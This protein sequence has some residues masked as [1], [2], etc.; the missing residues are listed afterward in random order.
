MFSQTPRDSRSGQGRPEG[1]GCA[2]SRWGRPPLEPTGRSQNTPP[3]DS[4]LPFERPRTLGFCEKFGVSLG[5]L[6][7]TPLLIHYFICTV[8]LLKGES[9]FRIAPGHFKVNVMQI[10]SWPRVHMNF[11]GRN[12]YVRRPRPRGV[13][14]GVGEANNLHNGVCLLAKLKPRLCGWGLVS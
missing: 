13:G 6:L 1:P 8:A 3:A 2:Y 12:A 9:C 5:A 7:L 4:F 11:S 14:G 10:F